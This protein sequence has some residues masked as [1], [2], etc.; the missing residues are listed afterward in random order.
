MS[1]ELDPEPEVRMPAA[2][3]I[4]RFALALLAVAT[5][6]AGCTNDPVAPEPAPNPDLGLVRDLLGTTTPVV[7]RGLS[8]VFGLVRCLPLDAESGSRSIGRAGG[9]LRVGEYTL[10]V[11][12]GAL[13]RTVRITMQQVSDTV[14]SV[15]FAPEGLRFNRPARLTMGYDNCRALPNGR[16]HR[17]VYVDESLR[18]LE[19]PASRDDEKNEDVTADIDHFSRYAVAW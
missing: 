1:L 16:S 6:T 8:L 19:T 13:D 15:R 5:V 14:N 18:V 9:T 11:P 17:I 3:Q 10:A 4:R 2:S 12:P 7:R